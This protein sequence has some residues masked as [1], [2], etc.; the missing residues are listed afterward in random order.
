MDASSI[1]RVAGL[2]GEAGRIQMLTVLLDGNG[3][4]AS[5]LAMAAAASPQT[6]SSHLSKLLAGGLVVSERNGRQRLFRLKNADVA[7][8]IEALGALAQDS[9]DPAMP[10]LRFART[11]YDH[12][13]GVLAIA[14]RNELQRRD[15]LRYRDDTFLLTT[16]GERFLRS[17]DIDAQ[18][19]R[20]MRRSFAR[21]CLDWTE[22]HH[23]IGGAVGAAMLS[24]FMEMKWLARLRRTRAVRL[25]HEGERG[26]ERIFG[27]RIPALRP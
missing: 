22:R 18:S 15:V 21:G 14:L 5:E 17:L 7:T 10:E 9:S 2:I 6:A 4:S 1:T 13:A 23:H 26:F 16:K 11:C 8:A 19:L 27:I 24:R 12:L 20:G 3:H 25:T